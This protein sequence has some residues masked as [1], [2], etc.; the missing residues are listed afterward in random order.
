MVLL[1]VERCQFESW[2]IELFIQDFDGVHR[3][4]YHYALCAFSKTSSVNY[5]ERS[6]DPAVH[7]VYPDRDG[8]IIEE[9]FPNKKFAKNADW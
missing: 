9:N 8:S 2:F 7:D 6:I 3:Q 5:F 1:F 4:Y